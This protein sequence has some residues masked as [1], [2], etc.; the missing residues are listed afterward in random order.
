MDRLQM[1]KLELANNLNREDDD[2]VKDLGYGLVCVAYC[3]CVPS[4]IDDDNIDDINEL[5]PPAGL[6]FIPQVR[7]EH[8]EPWWND[9]GRGKH[10]IRPPELPDSTSR[11]I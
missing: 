2:D 9:I 4:G 6:L 3:F 11:V 8:G 1:L 10:L 7:Y 5:R